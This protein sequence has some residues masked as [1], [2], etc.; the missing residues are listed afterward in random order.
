MKKVIFAVKLYEFAK[1]T[2]IDV[3]LGLPYL[4]DKR[5]YS[6]FKFRIL[7]LCTNKI[8][9]RIYIIYIRKKYLVKRY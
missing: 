2:N 6:I 3:F 4:D 7:L 5:N 8:N 9:A 1:L